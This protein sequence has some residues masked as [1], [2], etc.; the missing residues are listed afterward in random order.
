MKLW[1]LKDL[2][3]SSGEYDAADA[4]VVRAST[5][6]RARNLIVIKELYGDEGKEMWLDSKYSSCEVLKSDGEEEIIIRD[7]RAG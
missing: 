5:E 6:K 2:N 4:F 7:F 1:V 3:Q